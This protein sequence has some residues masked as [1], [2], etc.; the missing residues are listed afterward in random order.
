MRSCAPGGFGVLNTEHAKNVVGNAPIF[1]GEIALGGQSLRQP[2]GLIG[3]ARVER[4]KG[5]FLGRRLGRGLM[6]AKDD[7]RAHQPGDDGEV[8]RQDKRQTEG[9]GQRRPDSR[10]QFDDYAGGA[11]RPQEAAHRSFLGV[12]R[13]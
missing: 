6:I 8:H 11:A 3:L 2:P 4:L 10:A 12:C 9:I 1:I 5:C 13:P 7:A